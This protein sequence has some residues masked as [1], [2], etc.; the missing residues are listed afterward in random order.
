[1]KWSLGALNRHHEQAACSSGCCLRV[2][3][4]WLF[5]GVVC[6]LGGVVIEYGLPV[7]KE[8]HSCALCPILSCVPIS[9]YLGPQLADTTKDRSRATSLSVN[10]WSQ[11]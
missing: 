2:V 6:R 8:I 4:H 11:P 3:W 1:M 7:D 9:D 10:L 5:A